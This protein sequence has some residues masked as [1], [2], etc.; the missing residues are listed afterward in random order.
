MQIGTY[1]Q[2]TTYEQHLS[3]FHYSVAN[4]QIRKPRIKS[5]FFAVSVRPSAF[6]CGVEIPQAPIR[7][8]GFPRRLEEIRKRPRLV[9]GIPPCADHFRVGA[10][11][12][13]PSQINGRQCGLGNEI[14]PQS[15]D[16][17]ANTCGSCASVRGF[18]QNCH[19]EE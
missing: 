13:P 16:R 10:S 15:R 4:V 11:G 17:E 9:G 7:K 2:Q 6:W 19:S 1:T 8:G 5:G 18:P 14:C 3:Y 12:A